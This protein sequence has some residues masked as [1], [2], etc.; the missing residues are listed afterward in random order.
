V[1]DRP[2]VLTPHPGEAARLLRCTVQEVQSDRLAAARRIAS[3]AGATVVLK[4]RRSLVARPDGCVAVNSS[5]NPGMASGGTGDVLT[6]AVGA[7][8]ARGLDPW[9]AS[10]LA[11]F[12]HGDAGDRAARRLGVEGLIASDLVEELP[13]SLAALHAAGNETGAR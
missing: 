9:Q 8:L 1:P 7:F 2:L 10:R 5:G 3:A 6:G 4:G 13:A 11:V 12:V